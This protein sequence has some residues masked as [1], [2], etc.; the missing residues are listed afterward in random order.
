MER[1]E[2]LMVRLTA[3]EKAEVQSAA[4]A[5]GLTVSGWVRSTLLAAARKVRRGRKA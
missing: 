2:N 4:D 3:E 5:A 1:D